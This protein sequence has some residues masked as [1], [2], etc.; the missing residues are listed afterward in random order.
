[1]DHLDAY[2]HTIECFK[3]TNFYLIIPK[4]TEWINTQ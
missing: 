2:I 1:M 4:I 3:L